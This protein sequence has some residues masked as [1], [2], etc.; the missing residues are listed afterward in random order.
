MQTPYFIPVGAKFS[1]SLSHR[2][3]IPSWSS[4]LKYYADYSTS[5]SSL[6]EANSELIVMSEDRRNVK[7]LN[8]ESSKTLISKKSHQYLPTK[9]LF[10]NQLFGIVRQ[11]R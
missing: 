9:I 7:A 8:R 11:K 1:N 3:P 5:Y 6:L 2:T 4:G 10:T